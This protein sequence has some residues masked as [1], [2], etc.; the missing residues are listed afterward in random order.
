MDHTW[1]AM[2]E[3][4]GSHGEYA[5][6]Q[7]RHRV[8]FIQGGRLAGVRCFRS[9]TRELSRSERAVLHYARS[10]DESAEWLWEWASMHP[11]NW[12]PC[13]ALSSRRNGTWVLEHEAAGCWQVTRRRDGYLASTPSVVVG[14]F[15]TLDAAGCALWERAART[16]ARRAW[17][18]RQP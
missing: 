4:V 2:K 12:R 14:V 16:A 15:D 3:L 1:T 18:N 17:Q 8:G 5:L 9:T 10:V 11:L 6:F 7:R 13:D